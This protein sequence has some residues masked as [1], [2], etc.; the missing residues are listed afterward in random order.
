MIAN[1]HNLVLE[2]SMVYWRRCMDSD[3]NS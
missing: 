2:F 3:V 1:R